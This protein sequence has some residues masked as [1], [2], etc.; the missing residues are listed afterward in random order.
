MSLTSKILLG[1]LGLIAAIL[2]GLMIWEPLTAARY[3]PPPARSYDVEIIRDDYGVPHIYGKTYVDVA[4]GTAWAHA[5]DDF[6]TIQNTVLQARGRYASLAGMDGAPIDF[7][8][9][10][11]GA[12]D[13]AMTSSSASA[14]MPLSSAR[15]RGTSWW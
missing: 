11:L 9:N 13:T 2:I 1:L 8:Y 6:T 15:A 5:E 12:R 4:Y 14:T 7:I 3:D 10:V